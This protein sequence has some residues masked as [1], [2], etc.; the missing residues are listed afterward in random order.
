MDRARQANAD[1]ALATAAKEVYS[2]SNAMF[3]L[4][5]VGYIGRV[6][7][8]ATAGDRDALGT[9]QVEAPRST[10]PSSTT[11]PRPTRLPT[12]RSWRT[13]RRTRARSPTLRAPPLT[14]SD[15]ITGN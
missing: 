5:T 1:D 6:A 15:L 8:D 4:A 13:S 7:D 9:H 2:R 3:Y 11:L 12:T 10:N 14:N